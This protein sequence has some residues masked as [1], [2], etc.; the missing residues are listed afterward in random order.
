MFCAETVFRRVSW[1]HVRK[2]Y[3]ERLPWCQLTVYVKRGVCTDI[4]SIY[5]SVTDKFVAGLQISFYL[6]YMGSHDSWKEVYYE[7]SPILYR[8][9]CISLGRGSRYFLYKDIYRSATG[10]Q[11]SFYKI[12]T[13]NP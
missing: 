7:Y 8:I 4:D 6:T 12:S 2:G 5:H 10:V 1:L 13:L 11:I 9:S 3:R